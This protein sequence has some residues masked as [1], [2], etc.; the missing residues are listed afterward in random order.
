[1]DA[2][3]P[4][5][6][7][8]GTIAAVGA[9]C[10]TAALATGCTQAPDATSRHTAAAP[11]SE[12]G[13][14]V[15]IDSALKSFRSGLEPVAELQDGEPSIETLLDRFAKA[16]ERRDTV[17]LRRIVMT[18]REFAFLY[19]PTSPYT[20]RPTMQE[21]GLAWFL[22]LQHSEKGA[23]R[24]LNR[25]Q[26]L[27]IVA[28]R[29]DAAPREEGENRVWPDCIQRVTERGDTVPLRLFGGLLE[30]RGRFKIFSYSNDL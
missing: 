21:P 24:L 8:R 15:G 2:V 23:T 19:Y 7:L 16:V 14:P 13:S 4:E 1:M 5:L 10:L 9:L 20:R 27:R 12:G 29:C 11:T 6:T 30:R 18:K 3:R 17:E 26:P 25:G 28:N 22:H